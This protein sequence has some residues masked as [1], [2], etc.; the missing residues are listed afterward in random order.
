MAR[1]SEGC[2]ISLQLR[3]RRLHAQNVLFLHSL[4]KWISFPLTSYSFLQ[5]LKFYHNS[6][7]RQMYKQTH[8]RTHIGAMLCRLNRLSVNCCQLNKKGAFRS[9]VTAGCQLTVNYMLFHNIP[10]HNRGARPSSLTLFQ[11]SYDCCKTV[12]PGKDEP[13]ILQ[14]TKMLK[15]VS[16]I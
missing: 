3:G 7:T 6:R 1:S 10:K 13:K 4:S 15:L 8:G 14:K 12:Q 5:A 11:N 9:P 2:L 16:Q